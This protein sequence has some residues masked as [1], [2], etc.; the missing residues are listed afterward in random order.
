MG[1]A[2]T[3]KLKVNAI[4]GLKKFAQKQKQKKKKQEY[5]NGFYQ[6]GLLRTTMVGLRMFSRILDKEGLRE[7]LSLKLNEFEFAA[8]K[9]II[10]VVTIIINIRKGS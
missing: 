5:I 7:K 1:D 10:L 6:R 8:I 2:S 9:G 3:L 4:K